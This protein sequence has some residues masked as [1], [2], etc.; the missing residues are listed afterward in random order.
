MKQLPHI[1][2]LLYGQPWAI[3]PAVHA[4]FGML[5]RNYVTGNLPLAAIP[6]ALEKSGEA[7]HGI[8]YQADHASG[9]A[10]VSM[11]GAIVKRAP[12]TLCGPPTIDLTAFDA[13]LDD[14][15]ADSLISTLILDLNSPG[16]MMIG[17]QETAGRLRELSAQGIR[18]IA[19]TD[20]Q[21]CSAAYYLAAACDEIYCAPTAIIGSIGVYCAGLDDSRAWEMEGME[22][23]LAKSGNL[24]AMGHPGKA[25]SA[26]ERQWLQTMADSSGAEFRN[27]VTSRRGAVPEEA[28]QGQY[29]FAQYAAPALLDGL[30]RDIPALLADLLRPA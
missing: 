29:Y 21:M 22:L 28:M 20:Y 6:A 12:D 15:A 9:I 16:G 3:L 13:L 26:E 30:Y 14:I 27:W 2:S 18:T 4:E 17:L 11:S 24:K 1:A 5:Y 25:W 10:L 19:Y 7:C 23:I 8:N